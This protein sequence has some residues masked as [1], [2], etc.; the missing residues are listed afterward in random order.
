MPLQS[1][2]SQKYPKISSILFLYYCCPF[3]NMSTTSPSYFWYLDGGSGEEEPV[4]GVRGVQGV[5]QQRGSVRSVDEQ[6]VVQAPA[7]LVAFGALGRLLRPAETDAVCF[8]LMGQREQV[9]HGA[10]VGR[11]S[12]G[13]DESLSIILML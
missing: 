9:H 7:G 8:G 2:I 4:G 13:E 3:H 11:G 12:G 6:H 5:L 10:A 1:T